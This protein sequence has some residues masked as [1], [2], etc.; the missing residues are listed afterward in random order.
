M[1]FKAFVF[2]T[3]MILMNNILAAQSKDCIETAMTQLEMN[4]CSGISYKEA[5]AELNRVY[6]QIRK[7]Y[8]ADKEFLNKLKMAQRAWIKLRDADFE[9]QFPPT[10]KY[11]SIFPMCA[12][13]FKTQ[14]TLQR[15]EFLKRW[16]V[17]SDDSEACPGSIMS[18][19]SIKDA[20]GN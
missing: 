20:L 18:S 11:G 13:E 5:D 3:A 10:G 16:L 7:V 14:L 19:R 12:N 1:V 8:Q 2:L 9:L 17:G 4:E 6:K 15:V